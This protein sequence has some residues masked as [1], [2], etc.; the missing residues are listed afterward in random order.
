MT[1]IRFRRG[2]KSNIP[3]SAPSGTP[4]WCEDSKEFYIGTDSG[5]QKIGSNGWT[6]MPIGAVFPWTSTT[7]PDGHLEC[8]GQAVSRTTY[9]ELFAVLGT[10]FGSGDGSTTFNVPDLRA[11]FIRGLD[12]GR[13]V[14]IN[15]LLGSAQA[16]DLKSHR[17]ELLVIRNLTG[18]GSSPNL[19]GSGAVSEW[20][21]YTGGSETRPR[22]VAL[23][24]IIKAK[25][26]TFDATV[27]NANADTVDGCHAGNAANNV[28]KLDDTGKV[29][30]T[31]LPASDAIPA[32]TVS[33]FT[34]NTPPTGYLKCNGAAIS[35]TTYSTLFTAIGTTFGTGDGSTTFNLPDLRGEFIRGW[36]DSRGIDKILLA[37]NTTN[38]SNS[39]TTLSS[40]TGL[41]VGMPVSGSGI[42]AGA[43]IASIVNSTSITISANATATA[44][45]VSLTFTGR[46]FGSW[47]ADDFKAH[48]HTL[49]LSP[50][51]GTDPSGTMASPN[52]GAGNTRWGYGASTA[53]V[54]SVGGLETKPRN[55]ALL[56]C[57]K[58]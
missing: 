43:T 37:G 51:G 10:N 14:D 12:R 46:I 47:Q 28:L 34:K 7:I 50:L 23:V 22:N 4:L 54:S 19:E 38:A 58:Y 57:I 56:P 53:T 3:A 42:P 25:N 11:E 29:P 45:A 17:H 8:N 35:R 16:D 27:Q 5:V 1:A 36:D 20:T 49:T 39:I 6:S 48:N 33:F 15:R 41:Y 52:W 9:S 21:E 26:I 44:T 24:Y 31:N 13:G 40:T 18:V 55:I 30:L 32:G 2:T